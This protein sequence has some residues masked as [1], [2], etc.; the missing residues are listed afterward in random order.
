MAELRKFW[1]GLFFSFLTLFF[2]WIYFSPLRFNSSF[3]NREERENK[4]RKERER[5]VEALEPDCDAG[6][7]CKRHGDDPMHK[8]VGRA[9]SPLTCSSF[10]LLLYPDLEL[11]QVGFF[12]AE[13]DGISPVFLS[14]YCLVK[15]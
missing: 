14:S 5:L 1:C 9:G 2:S 7:S 13:H 8:I 15:F 4:L 10:F 3:A 6:N 12:V 11:S